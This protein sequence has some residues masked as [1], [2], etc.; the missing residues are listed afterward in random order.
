[1]S[2]RIWDWEEVG[3]S[4]ADIC[5]HKPK[6]T[7]KI[8]VTFASSFGENIFPCKITDYIT[9]TVRWETRPPQTILKGSGFNPAFK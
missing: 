5:F 2:D 1:M 9:G 4:D 6:S 3:F 7:H 8:H